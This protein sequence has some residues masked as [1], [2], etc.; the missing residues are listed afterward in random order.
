MTNC[1][2][3]LVMDY[4][5]QYRNADPGSSKIAAETLKASGGMNKQCLIVLTAL[6]AHSGSTSK[7][8]AEHCILD[9]YQI[10]RRLPELEANGYIERGSFKQNTKEIMWWPKIV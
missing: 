6:Q 7:E 2:R 9:R 3:Q 10:A 5:Q 4:A 8:L 1:P